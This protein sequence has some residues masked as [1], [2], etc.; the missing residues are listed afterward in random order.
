MT[1]KKKKKGHIC[2][3]VP[4]FFLQVVN[5]KTKVECKPDRML[6]YYQNIP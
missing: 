5:H 3:S 6:A 2:R 1:H 4:Q